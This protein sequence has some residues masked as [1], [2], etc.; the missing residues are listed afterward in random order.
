[1]LKPIE[2][3]ILTVVR[4]SAD[5]AHAAATEGQSLAAVLHGPLFAG[6]H[7]D[8][9]FTRWTFWCWPLRL[10]KRSAVGG[11]AALVGAQEA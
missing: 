5:A 10:P 1:M 7:L 3:T 6:L 4:E 8:E 2:G 11:G 9:L